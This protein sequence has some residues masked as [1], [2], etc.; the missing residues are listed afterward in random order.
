[1]AKDKTFNL[2]HI[3]FSPYTKRRKYCGGDVHSHTFWEIAYVLQG[4][5]VNCVNGEE[6]PMAFRDIVILRPNDEHYYVDK[7][8]KIDYRDIYVSE[9]TFKKVCDGFSKELYKELLEREK[10]LLFSIDTEHLLSVEKSVSLFDQYIERQK[11]LDNIFER[12]VS[13]I[14]SLYYETQITREFNSVQTQGISQV[15]RYIEDNPTEVSYETVLKMLGYSKSQAN[16]LFVKYSGESIT[17]KI[18]KSKMQYAKT[19]LLNKNLSIIEISAET[20]YSN[21]SNFVRVFKK[22]FGTTPSKWRKS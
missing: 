9:S 18:I 21:P 3:R 14:I 15:F 12:I 13:R 7:A 2:R 4:D 8:D 16:R 11:D 1:M 22:M 19:L 5:M 6:Y 10:P 17:T 20:G